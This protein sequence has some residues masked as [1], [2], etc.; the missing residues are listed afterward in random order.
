VEDEASVRQL[1]SDA[2]REPGYTVVEADGAETA[3]NLLTDRPGIA[4]LF[5]DV[6][7][8]NMETRKAQAESGIGGEPDAP[9][10]HLGGRGDSRRD[11]SGGLGAQVKSGA[12]RWIWE[13]LRWPSAIPLD[14]DVFRS[15][16]GW[17]LGRGPHV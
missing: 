8:P 4:P 15:A 13:G 14:R 1:T 16:D 2:R 5:T 12:S 11:L 10:R 17:G 9:E 6:V 3:L 7:M